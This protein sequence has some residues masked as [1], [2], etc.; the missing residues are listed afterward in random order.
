M[1]VEPITLDEAKL[2][3]RVDSAADNALITGLITAAR[4][5][6]ERHTGRVFITA[7][8]T[9]IYDG[10]GE[11]FELPYPPLQELTKIE[12]IDDA[13]V[14]TEVSSSIYDADLSTNTPGRVMLKDGNSWP[15]HRGFASFIVTF[16]AG[17][18]D[19]GSDVPDLIKQAILQTIAHLYENRGAQEGIPAAR[20]IQ[21][22]PAGVAVLLSSY[23]VYTL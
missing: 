21:D 13:G 1:A 14:K 2:H 17:Y 16:K 23:K 18:G 15:T 22:L 3:L 8:L 10:A 9:V 19:A 20:R 11:S 6:A 7:N 12:T 4:L 5:L